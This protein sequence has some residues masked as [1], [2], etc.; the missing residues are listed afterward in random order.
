MLD[1]FQVE[2]IER[3]IAAEM[4]RQEIPGLSAGVGIDCQLVW[5]NGFG[6]ADLENNVPATSSTV[7]RLAST[8]KPITATAVMQLVAAGK[9]RLD[10]PIQTYVPAF[11]KKRRDVTAWH[12]LTHTAG[13]RHYGSDDEWKNTRYF[14][15]LDEALDVFRHDEL[16]H[17]PGSKYEYSTYGYGVLGCLVESASGQKYIDYVNEQIFAPAGMTHTRIDDAA[18]IIPHRAAGYRK[19]DAGL[20]NSRPVDTSNKIPGAG[21]CA[22]VDD[23]SRFGIA[24]QQC[25]LLDKQRTKQMQRTARRND[26][27]PVGEVKDG[28]FIGYGL[29]WEIFRDSRGRKVVRH[30]GS[31]HAVKTVLYTLPRQQIVVAILCN[32]EDAEL[33]E[34]ADR[35]VNLVLGV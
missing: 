28:R 25:T 1:S 32:L 31:Q 18:A 12:L 7:Y 9:V 17:E 13:V 34:L 15:T 3:A 2:T 4:S 22:T 26:R 24:V 11:P 23:V 21:L 14:R 33:N 6:V 5:S 10:E 35:I 16:L 30:G 8:T 27:Q 20:R 19:T 29:G